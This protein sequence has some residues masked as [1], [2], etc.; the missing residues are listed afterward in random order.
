MYACATIVVISAILLIRQGVD[1]VKKPKA[2]SRTDLTATAAPTERVH[3][4]NFSHIIPCYG[5]P[6]SFANI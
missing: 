2:L 6:V 3:T 5:F 4:E 1:Q